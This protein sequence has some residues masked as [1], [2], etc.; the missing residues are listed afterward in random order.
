MRQHN[1]RGVDNS[2]QDY[3]L[4]K[5]VPDLYAYFKV[6]IEQQK[7][8]YKRGEDFWEKIRTSCNRLGLEIKEII[9]HLN[10]IKLPKFFWN[11]QTWAMWCPHGSTSFIPSPS[12]YIHG[13]G[14]STI[15]SNDQT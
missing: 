9:Y 12:S 10:I 2:K 11:Y 8:E 13:E 15:Q 4:R 5:L 3:I 7:E 14:S 1:E 6:Q